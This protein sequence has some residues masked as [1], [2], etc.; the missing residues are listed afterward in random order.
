M[1]RTA[2]RAH[3]AHLVIQRLPVLR[4]HMAAADD[5]VDLLRPR[6][7]A[8]ANFERWGHR[9]FHGENET[10]RAVFLDLRNR[11][12]RLYEAGE[13]NDYRS[14]KKTPT[15]HGGCFVA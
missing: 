2:G 14:E 1:G 3:L 8:F 9:I 15:E 7:H 4:Q 11:A 5:D 10:V 13:H 6:R 12:E